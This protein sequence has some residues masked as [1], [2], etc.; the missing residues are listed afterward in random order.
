MVEVFPEIIYDRV[1]LRTREARANLTQ[2][3][4]KQF[5]PVIRRHLTQW[6]HFVPVWKGE[7]TA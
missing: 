7:E 1:T 6:F 3:I 2:D 5:E 4:M